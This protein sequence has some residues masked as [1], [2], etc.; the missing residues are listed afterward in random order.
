M[1]PCI[2]CVI[3]TF[4]RINFLKRTLFHYDKQTEAPDY[5]II[6][7]NHSTDGTKDFL[8][9]WKNLNHKFQCISISLSE[10][11]GGSGGFYIGCKKA[12]DFDLDYI[13]LA[14]DDAYPDLNV[15]ERLRWHVQNEKRAKKAAA[16]CTTVWEHGRIQTGHRRRYKLAW[17]NIKPF[18]VP[19]EEYKYSCF[20][21]Q[22]FSY[23]GVAIRADVL[24]RVGLCKKGFFI[25]NDDAEHALRVAQCGEILCYT[26][27]KVVHEKP[28]GR[29]DEDKREFIDWH[30]YYSARNSYLMLK[31]HFKKQ[32]F[33]HWHLDYIKTK[34]HLLTHKKIDK[35]QVR[36]AALLDA[37][38]DKLG[39]HEVY[40]PGWHS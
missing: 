35:Y 23:V 16:I 27:M 24:R 29:K 37:K 33:I 26:D 20:A 15:F 36:L 22:L 31:Y 11:I 2:A 25:Y 7:D 6:V 38:N 13:W 5:L 1:K 10:N 17:D 8:N 14:D 39:I 40:R 34:L 32:Y 21:L 3:V 30:Y 4:N 18:L 19:E 12:L 28:I 9:K